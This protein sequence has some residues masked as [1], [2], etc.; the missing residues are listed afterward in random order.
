MAARHSSDY[1][2][3]KPQTAPWPKRPIT[4]DS[5][6]EAADDINDQS[7]LR[8]DCTLRCGHHL[9]VPDLIFD[10]VVLVTLIRIA[11]R[12]HDRQYRRSKSR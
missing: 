6:A 7:L 8:C 3:R 12:M 9:R 4:D 5:K 1:K 11:H 2:W 10:N